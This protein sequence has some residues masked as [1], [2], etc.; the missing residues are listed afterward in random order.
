M[1]LKDSDDMRVVSSDPR[2]R[3]RLASRLRVAR[4]YTEAPLECIGIFPPRNAAAARGLGSNRTHAYHLARLMQTHLRW[5]TQ[6]K[7]PSCICF[8]FVSSCSSL[9]LLF[10]CL[11]SFRFRRF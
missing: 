8:W 6:T 11:R 5:E 7:E 2:P 9:C 1:P 3:G 4:L 10:P